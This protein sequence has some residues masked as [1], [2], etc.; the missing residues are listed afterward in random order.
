MHSNSS[1]NVII[2]AV[3]IAAAT[4]IAAAMAIVAR[5]LLRLVCPVTVQRLVRQ[6]RFPTPYLIRSG[7]SPS[8]SFEEFSLHCYPMASVNDS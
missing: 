4:V 6:D 7:L 8:R 3:A 1:T 2:V 5:W